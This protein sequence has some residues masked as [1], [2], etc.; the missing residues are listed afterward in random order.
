MKLIFIFLVLYTLWDSGIG[1]IFGQD[2]RVQVNNNHEELK[3]I[4]CNQSKLNLSDWSHVTLL[5]TSLCVVISLV[6]I[7][8][9]IRLKYWSIIK[10]SHNSVTSKH[11]SRQT[12]SLE[13]PYV[14]RY[15]NGSNTNANGID[16]GHEINDTREV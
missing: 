5:I 4:I 1:S 9:F 6:L 10:A 16:I 13:G 2:C 8:C 12:Q 11:Q 15:K 14:I 3:S 7:C